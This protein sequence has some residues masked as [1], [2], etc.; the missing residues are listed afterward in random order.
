MKTTI[1]SHKIKGGNYT[2]LD[3]CEYKHENIWYNGI[4]YVSLDTGKKYIRE[5]KSFND[6]FEV[7]ATNRLHR[8]LGNIQ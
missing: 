5:E 4:L 1:Y 6:K 2:I 3:I 7:Y 8:L